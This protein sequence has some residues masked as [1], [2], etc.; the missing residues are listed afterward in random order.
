VLVLAT[1]RY[2]D[3]KNPASDVGNTPLHY[4]A[5]WGHLDVCKLFMA[6]I[7]DIHPKNLDGKTPKDHAKERNYI[8]ILQLFRLADI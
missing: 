7:K 2:V 3:E 1:I 6:N 8:H 4:A 5:K